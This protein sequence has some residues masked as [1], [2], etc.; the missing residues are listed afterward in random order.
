LIHGAFRAILR[1]PMRR[2]AATL[3]LLLVVACG[4]PCEDL[5]TRIC[6]CQTAG[7]L[8][9]TCQRSVKDQIGNGNPRPGQSEQDR[10]EQ[11]L[12]TCPDPSK[13]S[14][15]CDKLETEQGKIACGLAYPEPT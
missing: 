3:P 4:S 9:D 7:A 6:Q 5:G 11:L 10:C 1:R 15:A 2:L 13:D 14:T 12:K 8:R